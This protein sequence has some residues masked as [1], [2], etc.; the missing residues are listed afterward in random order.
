M[1]MMVIS[2]CYFGIIETVEYKKEIIV[3]TYTKQSLFKL[4]CKMHI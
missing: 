2:F 1:I 4:L 3:Y